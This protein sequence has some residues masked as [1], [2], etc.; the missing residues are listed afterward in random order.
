MAAGPSCSRRCA[1][2][3]SRSISIRSASAVSVNRLPSVEIECEA[4]ARLAARSARVRRVAPPRSRADS[5][6]PPAR[7]AS[8]R[9]ATPDRRRTARE[10]GASAS[11]RNAR[12]SSGSGPLGHRCTN[13]CERLVNAGAL[14]RCADGEIE[15]LQRLQFEDPLGVDGVGIAAQRFDP[16]DAELATGRS[17]TGGRGAGRGSGGLVW[18]LSI[19]RASASHSRAARAQ[20]AAIGVAG[21]RVDPLQEARCDCRR[22]RALQR[23]RH[24]HGARAHRH[25][26]IMRALAD[27]PL[28]RRQPDLRAHGPIEKG[29]ALGLRRPDRFVET[30]KHDEIGVEQARFEKTKDLQ[31]RMRA[32]RPSYRCAGR[33][34]VEQGA[35]VVEPERM[36]R[37]ASAPS[38]PASSNSRSSTRSSSRLARSARARRARRDRRGA[39]AIQASDRARL[40]P[41]SR[42]GASAASTASATLSI[43]R[44]FVRDALYGAMRV[45]VQRLRARRRSAR[46]SPDR[47]GLRAARRSRSPARGLACARGPA[48]ARRLVAK[49]REKRDI[50]IRSRRPSSAARANAPARV[51]AQRFAAGIV[52]GNIPAP[53]FGADAARNGAIRRDQRGSGVGRLENFAQADRDGQGLLALVGGFD[54]ADPGQRLRAFAAMPR[55]IA[56][57]VR[58]RVARRERLRHESAALVERAI[59]GNPARCTSSRTRPA[60]PAAARAPPAGA[61]GPV[62][63]RRSR[64][65]RAASPSRA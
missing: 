53:K 15:R 55:D 62:R 47:A 48:A 10:F 34:T 46:A 40:P 30:R 24:H 60:G 4:T 36:P 26:E 56:A 39:R 49:E 58:R 28:R 43:S 17:S 1:H 64:P 5:R 52:D 12:A 18:G 33:E 44:P 13:A 35:I 31:S 9:R 63:H 29:V 22:T 19:S 59:R 21:E 45:R 37:A 38:A 20:R 8:E 61:R 42:K 25:R 41:P 14:L 3:P 16:R 57:P 6:A 23:A 51:V 65:R 2:G 7:R 54:Q 32:L 11:I 50:G 27:A